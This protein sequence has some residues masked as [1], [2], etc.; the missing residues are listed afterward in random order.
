MFTY[1]RLHFHQAFV[2]AWHIQTVQVVWQLF[3]SLWVWELLDHWDV[4]I[5]LWWEPGFK[6]VRLHTETYWISWHSVCVDVKLMSVSIIIL[7][8]CSHTPPAVGGLKLHFIPSCRKS[9]LFFFRLP[10]FHFSSNF[11]PLIPPTGRGSCPPCTVQFCLWFL[12]GFCSPVSPVGILC[13]ILRSRP[14]HVKCIGKRY[15]V[16]CVLFCI[17]NCSS[18]LDPT[19]TLWEEAIRCTLLQCRHCLLSQAVF[20]KK[21]ISRRCN[22]LS[23]I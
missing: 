3:F 9:F 6:M 21:N 16:I 14:Y 20:T 18:K 5:T 15:V 22:D 19:S 7:M 13:N 10:Q 4:Q 2:Y 23:S 8:M 17:S 11:S 12:P 1:K